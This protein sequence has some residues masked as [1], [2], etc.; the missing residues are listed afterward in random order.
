[1]P[2]IAS[3]TVR[4]IHGATAV[5]PSATEIE[6]MSRASAHTDGDLRWHVD[7][8]ARDGMEGRGN[9]DDFANICCGAHMAR[10]FA[11]HRRG[12]NAAGPRLAA[13]VGAWSDRRGR[14]R[15]TL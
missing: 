6:P 5:S 7:M 3:L 9:G 2:E 10:N 11:C 8:A 15:D 1:M 4:Q 13:A 14:T 12:P